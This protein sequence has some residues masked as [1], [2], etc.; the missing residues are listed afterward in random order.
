MT[1]V[2]FQPDQRRFRLEPD[3]SLLQAAL[4][5]GVPIAHA[6]GGAARCSTCRL[7]VEDGI[8]HLSERTRARDPVPQEQ[9][10]DEQRGSAGDVRGSGRNEVLVFDPEPK[11]PSFLG[12]VTFSASSGCCCVA[13]C[14]APSP[15][16]RSRLSMPT[17][18]RDGKQPRK[19]SIARASLRSANVGT[20]T[21]ALPI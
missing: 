1:D 9:D 10:G 16:T 19:T 7:V 20:N 11:R 13:Q 12:Q 2:I 3:L 15:H 5:A 8:D 4:D 14:R 17:T 21:T 6:C 18:R